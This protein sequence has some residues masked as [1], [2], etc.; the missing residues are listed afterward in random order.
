MTGLTRC[1]IYTRKS[2][3]EGP[4]QPFTSLD[5]QRD[6]CSAYIKSQ[7]LE[8]WTELRPSYDDNGFSGA[9]IQRPALQQLLREIERGAVDVVVVYK[10]DRLTRSLIDFA[11]IVEQLDK[12]ETSFI[13]VTQA[14]NTSSSVG[15]LT[16]NILLTF[17]QFER[18]LIGERLRDKIAASRARGIFTGGRPAYGY[19]VRNGKLVPARR[20]AK[21]VKRIFA[22]FVTL[23]SVIKVAREL[24]A[25]GIRK[26]PYITRT[27][28]KLAADKWWE[29][30]L[31]SILS[32]R[33]YLGEIQH[34]GKHYRGEHHAII[35]QRTFDAAQKQLAAISH[36]WH[37]GRT[38]GSSALLTGLIVDDKGNTMTPI[39]NSGAKTQFRVYRSQADHR[40]SN[41]DVISIRTQTVD[42]CVL[43]C[44]NAC[45]SSKMRVSDGRSEADRRRV[46]QVVRRVEIAADGIRV[47]LRREAAAVKEPAAGRIADAQMSLSADAITFFFPL[48]L[49][50]IGRVRTIEGWREWTDPA[51]NSQATPLLKALAFAYRLRRRI[52]RNQVESIQK[53]A[54]QE[55]MPAEKILKTLQLAYLAP[56]IQKRIIEG[57]SPPKLA[58]WPNDIPELSLDW[59]QQRA[60]L[61]SQ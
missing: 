57:R 54:G 7:A 34:R 1:A 22:R 30:P 52:E 61:N 9:N 19:H 28:R 44:V 3:E 18:E 29:G 48:D 49:R 40:K 25:D 42:P 15:R 32:N 6:S 17:A 55:K 50:S 31:S 24:H 8:G 2:V 26:V 46:R 59:W 39:L 33:V 45:G 38:I 58:K 21:I 14:F 13:S 11:K 10:I 27:G 41:P 53:L 37:H 60:S 36:R 43:R 47:E 23:G 4:D 5:A 20:E 35:D 16:L 56:D 51:A 12:R